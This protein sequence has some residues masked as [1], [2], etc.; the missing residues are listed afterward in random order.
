MFLA[1]LA[2]ILAQETA[3]AVRSEVQGMLE[4]ASFA[5]SEEYSEGSLQVMIDGKQMYCRLS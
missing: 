3:E 2:P 1:S 5:C 4:N